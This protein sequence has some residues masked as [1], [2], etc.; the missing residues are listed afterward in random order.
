MIK[1]NEYVGVD[2]SGGQLTASQILFNKRVTEI[3]NFFASTKLELNKIPSPTQLK[4]LADKIFTKTNQQSKILVALPNQSVIMRTIEVPSKIKQPEKYVAEEIKGILG[5]SELNFTISWQ[6]L[7]TNNNSLTKTALLVAADQKI[8]NDYFKNLQT[9]NLTPLSLEPAAIALVRAVAYLTNHLSGLQ[10]AIYARNNDITIVIFDQNSI[11]TSIII[12]IPG[13]TKKSKN[14]LN[15]IHAALAQ[16]EE[17]VGYFPK[18]ECAWYAGENISATVF[19]TTGIKQLKI[20]FL[21]LPTVKL[22][23]DS[24]VNKKNFLGLGLVTLGTALKFT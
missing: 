14:I 5:A 13:D 1:D 24:K 8:I 10:L 7:K 21:A 2:L 9:S 23:F 18:I 16:Y 4:T 3:K 19:K 11:Y 22:K 12:N 20:K 15:A 17:L 6:W